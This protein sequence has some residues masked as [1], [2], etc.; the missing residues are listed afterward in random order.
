M[1]RPHR[2]A[3]CYSDVSNITRRQGDGDRSAAIVS[4]A[5]DFARP[6]ASRAADRFFI[7]PLFEPAAERWA[8]TW[9]LSIDSSSGT[10]PDAAIFEQTLPDAPLRPAIVAV[11]DRCRRTIDYGHITP[12]A[13]R[14]QQVQDARDHRAIVD[15]RFTRLT[16]RKRRL[17]RRP[18]LIRQPEQMT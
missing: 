3:G 14:L 15:P 6:T 1:E 13:S 2:A 18:C 12:A 10:G 9:L 16:A 11:R 5:V 4:Q 8:L 17:D 7:L